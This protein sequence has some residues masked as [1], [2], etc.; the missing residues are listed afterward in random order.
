M[1]M[2]TASSSFAGNNDFAGDSGANQ[3]GP[4]KRSVEMDRGVIRVAL[5]AATLAF[6][7]S[8]SQYESVA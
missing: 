7:I 2:T 3:I 4:W 8:V 6:A 1:Q 5:S